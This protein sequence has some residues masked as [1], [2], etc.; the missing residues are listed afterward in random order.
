VS[1][2][3]LQRLIEWANRE[4]TLRARLRDDMDAVLRESGIELTADER[5][6]VRE[7]DWSLSSEQHTL[8][9]I[10]GQTD[11]LAGAPDA[12]R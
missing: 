12:G 5:R 8:S 11:R 7:T 6:Q 4:P 3:G 10:E 9:S 1:Q 2:E